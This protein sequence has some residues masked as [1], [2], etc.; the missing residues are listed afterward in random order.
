VPPTEPLTPTPLIPLP[1]T[2]APTPELPCTNDV[3]FVSDVTAPDG[4]QYLPG[5]T[6]VKKWNVKNA[7]TC[8]WG[9]AYRLVLINGEA[10]GAPGELALYPARGGRNAILEIPMTAPN[11]PGQYTGRWR[12]RDPAGQLFGDFVSVR[13]EVIP[14]PAP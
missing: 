3:E 8:D 4:A 10:M 12:V 5:Q 9:P 1:A 6:F 2:E 13:I 7:G 11:A 14:L